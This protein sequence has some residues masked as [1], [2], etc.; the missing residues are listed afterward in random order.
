MTKAQLLF[1]DTHKWD[2]EGYHNGNERL[3]KIKVN[4]SN[5]ND[6]DEQ[7]LLGK[8]AGYRQRLMKHY[9]LLDQETMEMP[10]SIL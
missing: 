1:N 4:E 7:L 9:S 6:K 10:N 3:R 2:G 5:R 8:C